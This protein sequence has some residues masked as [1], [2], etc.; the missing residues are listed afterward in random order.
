MKKVAFQRV[1]VPLLRGFMHS[2][3]GKVANG[4]NILSLAL[5]EDIII[6]IIITRFSCQEARCVLQTSCS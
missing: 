2:S 5:V 6:I 1:V 3:M 4:A